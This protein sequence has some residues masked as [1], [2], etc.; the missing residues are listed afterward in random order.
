ME[1]RRILK[2]A[3]APRATGRTLIIALALLLL[4]ACTGGNA[5]PGSSPREASPRP[6]SVAGRILVDYATG[7][8]RRLALFILGGRTTSVVHLRPPAG[9]SGR[10]LVNGAFIGPDGAAYALLV[11]GRTARLY[12]FTQA[13]RGQPWGRPVP[14][15]M[16][17]PTVSGEG[18]TALVSD[19]GG[20]QLLFVLDLARPRAWRKV[21]TGCPATL[22]PDGRKVLYASSGTS[23]A[24]QATYPGG[25]PEHVVDLTRLGGLTAAGLAHARISRAA[26]AW[27]AGGIAFVASSGDRSALVV[28][29]TALGTRIVPLGSAA[30]VS[31]VWRPSGELVGFV[32]QESASGAAIRVYDPVSDALREVTSA[33][34]GL[35]G[36]LWSPDGM[37]LASFESSGGIIVYDLQGRVVRSLPTGLPSGPQLDAWAK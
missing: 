15:G 26:I 27:G 22:S 25:R 20:T 9:L 12:R 1:R 16:V 32:D 8:G 5:G 21:G 3:T 23:L 33:T 4:A 11:S 35:L 17:S 7:G 2:G 30:I 24:E 34:V 19:C 10:T 13:G 6:P 28:G 31:L 29:G 36:L 18:H 14:S 37:L